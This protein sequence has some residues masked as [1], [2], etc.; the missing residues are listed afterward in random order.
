MRA[1]ALKDSPFGPRAF[2]C[3]SLHISAIQTVCLVQTSRSQPTLNRLRSRRRSELEPSIQ[4]HLILL[5]AAEPVL[6]HRSIH[7]IDH[8]ARN[9]VLRSHL[10]QDLADP[11]GQGLRHSPQPRLGR[12]RAAQLPRRPPAQHQEPTTAPAIPFPTCSYPART[13]AENERRPA[14]GHRS[15]AP[16]GRPGRK[17]THPSRRSQTASPWENGI[18]TAS[19]QIFSAPPSPA[20]ASPTPSAP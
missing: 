14:S 10:Q 16:A 17:T 13:P 20:K 12:C 19:C 5:L 1:L 7:F 15:C 6:G 11:L 2:H 18:P 3:K 9:P 4:D 8:N